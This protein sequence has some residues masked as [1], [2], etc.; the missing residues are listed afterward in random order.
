MSKGLFISFEGGEGAG[1]STLI[2]HLYI[3]LKE[4]NYPTIKTFEPGGTEVGD[5]IRDILL[6]SE[7]ISSLS[8]LALFL[9]SRS[10]HVEK[11]ILPTI[12]SGKIILCDRFSDSTIAY[13]GIARGLGKRKVEDLCSFFTTNLLPDITFYLDIDPKIGLRRCQHLEKDRIENEKLSFHQTVR[14]AFLDLSEQNSKRFHVLNATE[15]PIDVFQ[16]A[17]AVILQQFS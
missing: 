3:R 11:V 14:K 9:A 15:K 1:K 12:N 17:L 6:Y 4:L 5:K 16:K 10:E 7:N 8:E 2:D 13:Q